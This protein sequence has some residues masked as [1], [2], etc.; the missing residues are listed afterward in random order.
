MG[1][2]PERIVI[3]GY[4]EGGLRSKWVNPYKKISAA[5]YILSIIYCLDSRV[6]ILTVKDSQNWQELPAVLS[7]LTLQYTVWIK[8]SHQYSRSHKDCFQG[9][10]TM[11]DSVLLESNLPLDISPQSFWVNLALFYVVYRTVYMNP[12]KDKL[13][14][15]HLVTTSFNTVKCLWRRPQHYQCSWPASVNWLT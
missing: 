7:V 2:L 15:E 4:K 5:C 9:I 6:Y 14:W 8:T 10:I 13:M 12:T 11:Q 3:H 1:G